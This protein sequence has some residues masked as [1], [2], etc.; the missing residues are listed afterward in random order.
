MATHTETTTFSGRKFNIARKNG[1]IDKEGEPHFFEWLN[2]A[3]TSDPGKRT[4]EQRTRKNGE[5]AHYELFKKIDGYFVNAVRR[6]VNYGDKSEECILVFMVD[7]A[8]DYTIDLGRFDGRYAMDFLKRILDPRFDA[9]QRISLSP[10]AI[11]NKDTGRPTIGVSVYSGANKMEAKYESEHLLGMPQGEKEENR[12]G[13]VTWYFDKAANWLWETANTRV[14]SKLVGDPI[15][16]KQ[17][18]RVPLPSPETV[19]NPSQSGVKTNH[20]NDPFPTEAPPVMQDETDS[21]PF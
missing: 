12:K 5:N 20:S 8:D 14:F 16:F 2:Q 9:T 18:V 21:L 4:F 13:D 17:P 3:P 19:L 15:S 11:T 1:Q 10:Y 7:G 6:L